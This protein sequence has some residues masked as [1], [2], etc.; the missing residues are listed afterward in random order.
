MADKRP[1][2]IRRELEKKNKGEY[3][4]NELVFDPN[5]GELIVK[6]KQEAKPSPDSTVLDQIAEDGFFKKRR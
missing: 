4:G 3:T 5:T 2:S 1:D 6:G